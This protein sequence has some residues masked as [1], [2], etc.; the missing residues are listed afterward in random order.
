M[1]R[2]SQALDDALL[3]YLDDTLQGAERAALEDTIAQNPL[4]KNRLEEL[5]HVHALLKASTGL[6]MPSKN[7][8]GKVMAR[9]HAAPSR[10]AWSIRNA[11][12]L[13]AGIVVAIGAAIFLASAGMFDGSATV[14]LNP[15]DL[16]GKVIEAPLPGVTFDINGKL[17]VNIIILLNIV[18]AWILLDRAILKPYFQRRMQAHQ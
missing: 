8:A 16:P 10:S 14:N 3:E 9:I 18:V 11:L 13:L 12:I 2:I 6:E 15:V 7:F 4:V 1:E 5:R 17:L